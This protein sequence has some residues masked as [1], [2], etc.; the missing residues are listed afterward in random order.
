MNVVK[1]FGANVRR[2]RRAQGLSQE[3]LAEKAGLHRTYVGAVEREERNI[4][5]INADRIAQALGVELVECLKES[6]CHH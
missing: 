1:V 3:M 6:P 5:L 2:L 4:T